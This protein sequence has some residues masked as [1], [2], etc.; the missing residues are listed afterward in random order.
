MTK[1]KR[2]IKSRIPMANQG[3][4]TFASLGLCAL[5]FGPRILAS[6]F[7]RHLSVWISFVM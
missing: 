3:I 1:L 2:Q 6:D 7:A 4:L 5:Q